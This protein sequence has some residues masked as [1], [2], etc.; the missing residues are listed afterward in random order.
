[1]NGD[2][3]RRDFL[4]TATWLP[5]GAAMGLGA[6]SPASAAQAPIKRMGGPA[7]KISLNAYSFTGPL[8]QTH[9][10][11]TI[12]ATIPLKAPDRAATPRKGKKSGNHAGAKMTLFDLIDFCAQHNID[13]CDPTGYFFPTY[14]TPP[15]DSYLNDL[16]RHAFEQGVGLSG[17][18]VRNN[19]TTIDRPLRDVSVQKVK[20]WVEVAAKLGAPVLRVFC[21]TQLRAMT[22]HDV[23]GGATREQ[24]RDWIIADL[25]E[26]T[27]HGKRFGVIIGVQNHGDFLQTADQVLELI[28]GVDSEWCGAIVDTG[29]FNKAPDPYAEMAK[30][31]PYAVN[32]QVKQSALGEDSDVPLDLVRLLRIIRASGYRG[33]LPIETLVS[34]PYVAVPEMVQKL[35]DAIAATA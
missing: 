11:Q 22:W 5:F 28:Q 27:E 24:V 34:D 35:R 33:F 12:G 10:D 4:K 9:E 21:D 1:M 7:F 19:F 17:T 23:A 26:C 8:P 15:P 14:P 3:T 20:N 30:V 25:K 16:K 13:G 29:Y 18:G 6:A 2:F 31:A 32:W